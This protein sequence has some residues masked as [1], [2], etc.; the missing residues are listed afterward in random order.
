MNP[1]KL[2]KIKTSTWP[3]QDTNEILIT[4]HIFSEIVRSLFFE[5]LPYPD[6]NNILT[7]N[8]FEKYFLYEDKFF[9]KETG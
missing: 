5:I 1:G 6:D 9:N 8:I 7:E 3:K 2:L 4:S